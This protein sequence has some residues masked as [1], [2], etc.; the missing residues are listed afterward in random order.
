MLQTSTA[1]A[2]SSITFTINILGWRCPCAVHVGLRL[3]TMAVLGEQGCSH[4]CLTIPFISTLL[5]AHGSSQFEKGEVVCVATPPVVLEKP[6]ATA[7][8]WAGSVPRP[9]P[10]SSEGGIQAVMLTWHGVCPLPVPGSSSWY[11]AATR[12]DG[13]RFERLQMWW[14]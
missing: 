11:L 5:P 10:A 7:P 8:A 12:I 3:L 13:K 14:L 4:G 6:A 2:I 9:L 1:L